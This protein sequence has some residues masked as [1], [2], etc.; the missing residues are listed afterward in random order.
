VSCLLAGDGFVEIEENVR[1]GGPR[2]QF[3]RVDILQFRWW[4]CADR[5]KLGGFLREFG[6]LVAIGFESSRMRTARWRADS[7]KPVSLRRVSAWS[8]VLVSLRF[9]QQASRSAASKTAMV[10]GATVRFQIV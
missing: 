10:G 8:G 3:T 4:R 2:S 6:K 9:T 1:E 7:T 5:E